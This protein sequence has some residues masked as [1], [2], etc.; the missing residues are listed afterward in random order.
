MFAPYKG[1]SYEVFNE[2]PMARDLILYCTQNVQYLPKL[3]AHYQ[4]RLG[5]NWARKVEIATRE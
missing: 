2:R 3:W 5:A 4:S 1:G